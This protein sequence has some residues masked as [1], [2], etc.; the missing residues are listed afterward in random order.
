[1]L[2]YESNRMLKSLNASTIDSSNLYD[3]KGFVSAAET[4]LLLDSNAIFQI[5]LNAKAQ[6]AI[7]SG[8]PAGASSEA[9]KGGIFQTFLSY[10]LV[11][12]LVGGVFIYQIYYKE[13]NK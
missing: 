5:T 9:K 10:L 13:D 7:M 4:Y 12:I 1:M 6:A 8:E 2:P 11:P 3:I